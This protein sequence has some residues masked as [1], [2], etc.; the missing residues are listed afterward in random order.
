MTTKSLHPDEKYKA[1]TLGASMTKIGFGAGILL[2]VVAA[3]LAFVNKD[4]DHYRRFQFGYLT[5][6]TFIWSIAVGSI[7]FVLIHHLARARW[8][9]VVRRIAENI[10]LT[11]PVIGVLGL[12][13]ILPML[14]GND[15]LYFWSYFAKHQD[16]HNHHLMTKVGWLSP[17]F[18]LIR[19]VIYIGIYTGLATYFARK[20]RQQDESGDPKL[21]EQMRITSGWGMLVFSLTT[22]MAGFD[23]LMSLSPEWYS[24]IYSVNVFGGAMVAFYAFLAILT[25]A[26][27]KTGRLTHSVNAEHYQ[28]IGKYLFGFLFFWAYTAF[29]Q[30]MLIWY[31]NIP[32]EVIWYRY[33]FFTDWEPL[34]WAML[35]GWAIPYV[36]LLSRWPK[37]IMPAFMALCVWAL[38][39]H[40]LDIYWNV[41]PNMVWGVEH[42]HNLGPLHGA[43]AEHHYKFDIGD[44]L[45]LLSMIALFIGAV[46]RQ[47]K[48]NIIPVKDP[49]LGASLAF[50]NY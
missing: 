47:M 6:W 19:Y 2:L 40:Y 39:H 18:F 46:G 44:V 48:G 9:T 31:A 33:R 34:S 20:S 30:F 27:Q 41:M 5:A 23:I 42:G 16:P 43:L 25:R 17:G 29:S 45:L 7:F 38:L 24:T 50:E 28:D 15:N 4:T 10:S 8:G 36:I 32:E 1:G 12:G 37:R 22:V 35:I 3:I 11:M 49:N 13:F 14:A 26:I 21:S